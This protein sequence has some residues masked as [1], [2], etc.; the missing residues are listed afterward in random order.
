M[1]TKNL[2][3]SLV[4]NDDDDDNQNGS[5]YSYGADCDDEDDYFM[6]PLCGTTIFYS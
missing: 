4:R 2:H 3:G 1:V 5:V 6:R